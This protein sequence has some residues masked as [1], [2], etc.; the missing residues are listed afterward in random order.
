VSAD[1]ELPAVDEDG[2][3]VVGAEVG[4]VA[5]ASTANWVP[6][7]TVTWAP[8][9]MGPTAMTTAPE[10]EWATAWAAA[11]SVGVIWA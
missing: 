7:T 6:V 10:R 1:A 11:S 8:S 4:G 9:A 2:A 5:G 3:V